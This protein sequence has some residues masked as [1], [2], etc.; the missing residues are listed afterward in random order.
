MCHI[1]VITPIYKGNQ[2]IPGL[3]G[4]IEK[5]T[6][7]L[8]EKYPAAQV[9]LILVNDSPE[10]KLEVLEKTFHYSLISV[11]HKKNSGIHR[12]RVTGL[13][14]ASGDY[15]LFLDQDDE[16]EDDFFLSQSEKIGD[17]DVIVANAWIEGKDG[18]RK[19]KYENAFQFH[20]VLNLNTYIKA[21]NQITSPG[22]CL[23]RKSAI[24]TEWSR[25]VIKKNGSDDLMLWIIMLARGKK[26]ILNE[27]ILYTHK[28]TGANLSQDVQD[29]RHSTLEIAE[30][31]EKIEGIDKKYIRSLKRSRSFPFQWKSAGVV[32][33][34]ALFLANADILLPRLYWK[35]RS[36]TG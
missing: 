1:S 30:Y 34:A 19:R 5:N 13:A 15:I 16:I 26:F 25:Y 23:L 8:L 20:K 7:K 10:V 33:K 35:I 18:I 24:P 6:L 27:E 17:S 2:Y 28:Y 9:E 29:M 14:K 3:T 32:K 31:L 11:V 21:Y 36:L 4:M 12:A 22:Q